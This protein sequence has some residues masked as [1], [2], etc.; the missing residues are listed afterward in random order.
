MLDSAPLL[1]TQLLI[2][3]ANLYF[4]T[5]IYSLYQ[6]FQEKTNKNIGD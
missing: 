4:F 3:M 5:H 6:I 2:F 1:V